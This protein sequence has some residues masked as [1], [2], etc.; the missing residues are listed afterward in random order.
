MLKL[1]NKFKSS[2]RKAAAHTPCEVNLRACLLE[3]KL[4]MKELKNYI[5]KKEKKCSRSREF[6]ATRCQ[7]T[8]C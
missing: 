1:A 5:G 6:R 3:T 2:E 7:S 8:A 4:K